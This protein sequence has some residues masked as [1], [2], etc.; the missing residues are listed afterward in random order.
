MRRH[1]APS[2]AAASLHQRAMHRGYNLY[3]LPGMICG[4]M[5]QLALDDPDV[6]LF[7]G[8]RP[9]ILAVPG[10]SSWQMCVC[11]EPTAVLMAQCQT[12][13]AATGPARQREPSGF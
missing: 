4:H 3:D 7:L 2:R 9:A 1:A 6:F 12:R 11:S 5:L 10:I 13:Q 8:R